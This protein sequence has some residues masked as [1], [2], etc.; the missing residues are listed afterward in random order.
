MWIH[1][2]YVLCICKYILIQLHTVYFQLNF[3]NL[4]KTTTNKQTKKT[5]QEKNKS[6]CGL[7]RLRILKFLRQSEWK[8]KQSRCVYFMS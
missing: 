5:N 1:L 7:F 6:R 8:M 2:M 3:V 4:Q